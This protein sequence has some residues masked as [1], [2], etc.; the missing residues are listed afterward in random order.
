M[1]A[2]EIGKPRAGGGGVLSQVRQGG[3]ERS[4]DGRSDSRTSAFSSL[5]IRKNLR[6]RAPAAPWRTQWTPRVCVWGH[7]TETPISACQTLPLPT[8]LR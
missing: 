4:K 8:L 2:P 5:Q 1:V 6:G 3:G 7:G